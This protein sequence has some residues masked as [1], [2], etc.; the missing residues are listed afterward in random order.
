DH[1]GHQEEIQRIPM[2]FSW[3]GLKAAEPN[4]PMRLVDVLPTI[5]TTMNIDFNPADLDGEAIEL[6]V[7][8]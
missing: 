1:G 6:P 3:P 4:Q 7:R 5:L 2:I 8:Q